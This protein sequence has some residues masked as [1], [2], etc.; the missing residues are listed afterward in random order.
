MDEG[1]I[2]S[3]GTPEEVGKDLHRNNHPM[4]HSMTSAMQIYA[5]VRNQLPYPITVNE[6]RQWI[7]SFMEGKDIKDKFCRIYKRKKEMQ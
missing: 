6:G 4:V 3:E 1:S 2:I 5:G 7:D